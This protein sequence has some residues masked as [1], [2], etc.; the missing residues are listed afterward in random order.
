MRPL[1]FIIG[2]GRCGSTLLST[3]MGR[4]PRVLSL[5]EFFTSIDP[6]AFPA[7][8]IDGPQ[9][10]RI[11]SRPRPKAMTLLRNGIPPDEFLYPFG[12]GRFTLETGIP[13]ICLVTLPHLTDDPDGLFDELAGLIPDWPAAPVAEQYGRL[14]GWLCE[15]FDRDVVME[16]SGGSLRFL[17]GI[18]ACFPD[19]R[20]VYLDRDGVAAAVSMSRHTTFRLEVCNLEMMELLGVDPFDSPAVEHADQLPEELR[21]YLPDRFD[22]DALMRRPIPLPFFGMI[23]SQLIL[24]GV[25]Y[26]SGL[27]SDRLMYLSYE[28]VLSAPAAQLAALADFVGVEAD[29]QWLSAAASLVR[30]SVGSFGVRAVSAEDR[31]A[32]QEACGPGRQAVS[33]LRTGQSEAPLPV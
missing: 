13:P 21:C 8:P 26:L 9:F 23:W 29:P 32:L 18:T 28:D 20:F 15:R 6:E 10:W 19:A 2:T 22:P 17:E 1:T 11:L 3:A 4:H 24:D 14:F 30:P 5:S 27:P 7:G 33:E 12:S 31:A 16:R 25:G